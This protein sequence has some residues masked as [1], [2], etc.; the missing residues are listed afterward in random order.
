MVGELTTCRGIFFCIHDPF[1]SQIVS[2]RRDIDEAVL[3]Y[4]LGRSSEIMAI[5]LDGEG[6]TTISEMPERGKA[7]PYYGTV[8]GGFEFAFHPMDNLTEIMVDAVF[9]GHPFFHPDPIAPLRIITS[10][11][12]LSQAEVYEHVGTTGPDDVITYLPEFL[13]GFYGK[14]LSTFRE[15]EWYSEDM[16]KYDFLFS[17]TSVGTAALVRHRESD[18]LLDLTRDANW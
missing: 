5:G 8:G 13:F 11:I 2:W 9:A 16:R 14:Y 17:P 1:T 4:Q 7:I 15:W 18:T 12:I 3:R 6:L 10:D